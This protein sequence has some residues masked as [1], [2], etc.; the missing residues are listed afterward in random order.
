MLG[1]HSRLILEEL[2]YAPVEIE[3]LERDDIV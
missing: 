2:G 1:E 3:A